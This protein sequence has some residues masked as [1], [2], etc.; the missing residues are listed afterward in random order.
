MPRMAESMAYGD[1]LTPL[2]TEGTSKA[3]VARTS[4]WEVGP[5]EL[6]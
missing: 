6:K 5:R 3:D 2:P 4:G 1:R